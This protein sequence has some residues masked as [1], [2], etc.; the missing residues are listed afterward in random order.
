[1]KFPTVRTFTLNI[2]AVRTVDDKIT[3]VVWIA[4]VDFKIAVLHNLPEFSF[5]FF[6]FMSI[7]AHPATNAT[8]GFPDLV[9]VVAAREVL[10]FFPPKE[11][12]RWDWS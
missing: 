12:E 5:I 9:F 11:K 2:L 6:D 4:V 7:A 3:E 10:Y 8:N 1:M